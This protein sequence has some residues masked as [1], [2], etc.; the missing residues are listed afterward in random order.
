MKNGDKVVAVGTYLIFHRINIV[1]HSDEELAEFLEFQQQYLVIINDKGMGKCAKSSFCK[2][3]KI[4]IEQNT[5]ES[6]FDIID[7]GF[8]FY[9]VVWQRNTTFSSI[10]KDY[11]Q[12]FG[13][14]FSET[15]LS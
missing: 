7:G 15:V 10:C 12:F 8:L 6:L 5:T 4:K 14:N 11:I 13:Q 3:F 1:N 2:D 9:R